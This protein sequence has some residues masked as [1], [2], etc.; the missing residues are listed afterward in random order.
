[1]STSRVFFIAACLAALAG[2]QS[3][4]AIR[5]Q[6][7]QNVRETGL[8]LDATNDDHVRAWK[9]AT[10][11]QR[12]DYGYYE[13]LGLLPPRGGG[14]HGAGP[15]GLVLDDAV[16]NNDAVLNPIMAHIANEIG[17]VPQAQ[18][19]L[20]LKPYLQRFHHAPADAREL[21]RF[22]EQNLTP[23]LRDCLSFKRQALHLQ[24][25]E[26]PVAMF[27]LKRAVTK[28]INEYQYDA[29]FNTLNTLVFA[30]VYECLLRTFSALLGKH[31]MLQQAVQTMPRE[32]IAPL[33]SMGELIARIKAMPLYRN[34]SEESDRKIKT[35]E[36]R[37]EKA[38]LRLYFIYCINNLY[39]I[40]PE[41]L[42]PTRN[43]LP[44]WA[45]SE[46]FRLIRNKITAGAAVNIVQQD[47]TEAAKVLKGVIFATDVEASTLQDILKKEQV[48]HS[49]K[50]ALCYI[51]LSGH[52]SQDQNTWVKK[53]LEFRG[54]PLNTKAGRL[55][56]DYQRVRLK[57][58]TL[59]RNLNAVAPPPPESAE[60]GP[61]PAEARAFF[62]RGAQH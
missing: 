60:P 39:L 49:F 26:L 40:S 27:G 50:R 62:R 19:F 24:Y 47:V 33:K 35:E 48:P 38:K 30:E 1:M 36:S 17:I 57:I 11:A 22:M 55:E 15:A 21:N 61:T 41:A 52:L 43:N 34:F 2:E 25:Q 31:V 32:S 37:L 23:F 18:V 58:E 51:L 56:T 53:T 6:D 7:R 4:A 16:L 9:N 8:P 42:S 59:D 29:H 54:N 28:I 12:K 5:P 14:G 20:F 3:F 13:A 44:Q 45:Y 46:I 10:P